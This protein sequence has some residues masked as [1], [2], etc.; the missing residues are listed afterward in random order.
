MYAIETGFLMWQLGI[1]L[2]FSQKQGDLHLRNGH[3]KML[4]VE[5]T[6]PQPWES[7]SQTLLTSRNLY[8]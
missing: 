3:K 7:F 1:S 4:N 2:P 8:T 5:E 6:P